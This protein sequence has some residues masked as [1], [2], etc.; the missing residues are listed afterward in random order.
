MSS[1]S[2][3]SIRSAARVGKSAVDSDCGDDDE[4]DVDK[5][6]VLAA[7]V[8]TEATIGDFVVVD[9]IVAPKVDV[10]VV[11]EVV[12]VVVAVVVVVV[13]VA[14]AVVVV[15]VVAGVTT[16]ACVVVVTDTPLEEVEAAAVVTGE[17]PEIV[18]ARLRSTSRAMR[19]MASTSRTP[20]LPATS[21]P[22]MRM[23]R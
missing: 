14:A 16:G 7:G 13:V 18:P 10:T 1:S 12:E 20:E 4:V 8:S 3:P 17:L 15:V 19:A 9:A 23:K 2:S 11:V 21:S 6:L 5:V 22:L